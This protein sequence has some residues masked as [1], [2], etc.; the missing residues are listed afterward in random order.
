MIAI[1][2]FMC[3]RYVYVMHYGM[4]VGGGGV[5]DKD[6]YWPGLVPSRDNDEE[7]VGFTDGTGTTTTGGGGKSPSTK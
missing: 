2:M 1:D 4:V 3:V 6:A 7:R 5:L